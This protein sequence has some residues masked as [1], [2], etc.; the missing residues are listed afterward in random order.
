MAAQLWFDEIAN[1]TGCFEDSMQTHSQK[2]ATVTVIVPTRNEEESLHLVLPRIP[3]DMIDELLL[4]DGN[5]T[6][7]TIEKA[8]EMWPDVRIV[9]QKGRG[10]G[11]ALRLG[12]AEAK[13]DI[14]IT[15]DADGSMEPEK[16]PEFLRLL[17]DGYD[18]VKGSRF[19]KGGGTSDMQWYR[20]VANWMMT[21][22]ANV[23]HGSKYTD[24]TYGYNAFW[25]K[26]LDG[27]TLKTTDFET[28]LEFLI[29][30]ARKRLKIT[31]LPC[32]EKKRAGGASKLNSLK[33]G[34][35]DFK[36]ILF[37]PK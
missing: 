29:K 14:I 16:I 25:K 10:K 4:V 13:G 19:C 28:E 1:H 23:L 21:K 3:R 36:V 7:K 35:N 12:F 32:F 30:M 15:L 33:D 22:L 31:E 6:D 37:L 17:H 5:S 34:W 11:D 24:I 8:R 9:N 27:I 26:T 20:K 18:V 2:T